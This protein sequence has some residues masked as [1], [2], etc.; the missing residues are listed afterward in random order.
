MTKPAQ[1]SQLFSSCLAAYQQ[2]E[3]SAARDWAAKILAL[4]SSHHDAL[5]IAGNIAF[6]QNDYHQARQFYLRALRKSRGNCPDMFNLANTLFQLGCFRSSIF[7]TSAV[8][9]HNPNN[10]DA[11]L[12]RGQADLECEFAAAAIVDFHQVLQLDSTNVWACNYLAQALQ[13]NG[14]W[15]EAQAQA[16]QA[17]KL[18]NGDDSQ[19]LNMA[20]TLYEI[21]LENGVDT[22]KKYSRLWRQNYGQNPLVAY[23]C[24]ALDSNPDIVRSN[25]R[26]VERVFDA[27]A[28]TF[29]D[30]LHNLDYHVPEIIARMSADFCSAVSARFPRILDLGCGTGLCGQYLDSLLPK[31]EIFGVDISAAML[32]KAADKNV[33]KALIQGDILAVLPGDAK[34]YDLIIAADVLTYFGSLD[35]LFKIVSSHLDSQGGFVFSITAAA[36]DKKDW[37]LHLSGR[38]SHREKYV[39]QCLDA[40]SLKVQKSDYLKLRN[41]GDKAV[42]GWVFAAQKI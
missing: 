13:K 37:N 29:D 2:G 33:Y 10:I 36:A 16:Y 5:Q 8:L 3:Y 12:L 23:A 7:W 35:S 24:A 6:L 41:E 26:Y 15:D 4:D 42:M 25:T 38:F 19:H 34:R 31:A 18:S 28:A 21:A 22:I 9:R 27:F 20:Y 17:V 32:Q 1:I 39:R 11:L 40:A 30:S 14:C